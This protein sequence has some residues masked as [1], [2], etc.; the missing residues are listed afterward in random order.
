[1]QEKAS[2]EAEVPYVF[3]T[4]HMCIIAGCTVG[5]EGQL[6]NIIQQF[7]NDEDEGKTMDIWNVYVLHIY[8]LIL[9]QELCKWIARIVYEEAELLGDNQ[10][11]FHWLKE[12]T[13]EEVVMRD[14]MAAQ[15]WDEY[16]EGSSRSELV[17][18][19]REKDLEVL[20]NSKK[21]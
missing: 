12:N 2:V 1:M 13:K 5:I 6:L 8:L 4:D 17:V 14:N 21:M 7:E 15:Y 3:Q 20:Y 10:I 11:S 16:D 18:Q 19:Q 9:L